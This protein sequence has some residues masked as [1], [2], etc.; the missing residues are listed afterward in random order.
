MRFSRLPLLAVLLGSLLSIGALTLPSSASGTQTVY[1]WGG[2][3]TSASPPIVDYTPTVLTGI[4]GTVVQIEATNANYYVLTSDG[5]LWAAG[6]SAG[7]GT[8]STTNNFTTAVKVPFPSGVTIASIPTSGPQGS[9]TVLDTNGNVWGWGLNNYGQLC[10]GNTNEVTAPTLLPLSHVTF[11]VGAGDHALYVS[12]GTVYMCG[13]NKN[14]DLGNGSTTQSLIPSA[15][16]GLPSGKTIAR[17]VASWGDTGILY[18]DGSYY[19]WGFG[20]LGDVGNGTTNNAELPT[21]VLSDVA[22]VSEG[23]GSPNDGQ[24]IAVLTNGSVVSWGAD[25]SGQLCNGVAETDV[26]TPTAI[27]PPSTWSSVTSSGSTSF[28]LDTTGALWSC[29]SNLYGELG[30]H[31][32]T[33]PYK[34]SFKNPLSGV[35]QF[36]GTQYKEIALVAS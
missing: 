29:G 6:M 5:S 32:T 18:T 34:T 13:R 30:I 3:N 23:G 25:A 36:S 12:N 28:G 19:D 7:L 10:L 4:T 15:V 20:G 22:Q 11:T 35:T 14:G 21:L 31:Q 1:I 2:M 17:V 8:G 16:Q 33:K 27:T 26:T 9:E 24:T